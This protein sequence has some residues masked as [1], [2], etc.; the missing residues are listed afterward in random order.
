MESSAKFDRV[1]LI[2]GIRTQATWAEMVAKT[3]RTEVNVEV[4]PLRYGYFD[5]FRFVS[6]F[7]TRTR[8]VEKI[9][10]ELR[11]IF[12][13][14][15]QEKVLVIAHS[16]GTYIIAKILDDISCTCLYTIGIFCTGTY[17]NNMITIFN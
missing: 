3:L 1:V 4:T 13:K 14:V 16:F 7:F 11:R 15:P 2:H 6:P 12:T 8:P 9:S 10:R 17:S 5:V